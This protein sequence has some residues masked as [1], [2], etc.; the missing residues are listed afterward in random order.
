MCQDIPN[1]SVR[2]IRGLLLAYSVSAN[3]GYICMWRDTRKPIPLIGFL[4]KGQP[5]LEEAKGTPTE[6]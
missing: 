4:R 1:C 3:C 2:P 5:D 6:L